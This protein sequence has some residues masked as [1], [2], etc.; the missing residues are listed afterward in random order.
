MHL[1]FTLFSD[2]T[3]SVVE[4]CPLNLTSLP[5]YSFCVSNKV[6]RLVLFI[7][8]LLLRLFCQKIRYK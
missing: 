4:M 2:K 5:Y 8:C 6:I 7:P 1:I 3:T